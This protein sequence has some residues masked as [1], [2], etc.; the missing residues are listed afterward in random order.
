[1]LHKLNL[2]FKIILEFTAN[3]ITQERSGINKGK[4]W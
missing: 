1:M 4:E 2:N 3:E